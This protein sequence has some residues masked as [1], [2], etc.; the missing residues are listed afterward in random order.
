L[1]IELKI[2]F[3]LRT[4]LISRSCCWI[5]QSVLDVLNWPALQSVIF[6][7]KQYI[8]LSDVRLLKHTVLNNQIFSA[9]TVLCPTPTI[10]VVDKTQSCEFWG[11]LELYFYLKLFIFKC[12]FYRKMFIKF[13]SFQFFKQFVVLSVISRWS[14]EQYKWWSDTPNTGLLK[15]LSSMTWKLLSSVK[16]LKVFHKNVVKCDRHP[17]FWNNT[18]C[19]QKKRKR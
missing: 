18:R 4:K 5:L 16:L 8:Q 1:S 11:T 6:C 15:C 10:F 2:H 12:K 17:R 3:V 14:T 9:P 13:I 7:E 19:P